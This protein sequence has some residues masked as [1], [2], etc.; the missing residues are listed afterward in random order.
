MFKL[1]NKIRKPLFLFPFTLF[2]T[3]L[4]CLPWVSAQEIPKPKAQ[5]WQIDGIIAALDDSYPKVKQYA[6][7]KLTEYERQDLKAML[8][9]PE[10]IALIAVNLLRDEKVDSFIRGDGAIAIVNR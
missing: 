8:K 5:P 9:K 4:L 3:L 1:I 10:N 7:W 6:F 2:L